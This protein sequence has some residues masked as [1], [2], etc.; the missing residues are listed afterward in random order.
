MDTT[1]SLAARY[2]ALQAKKLNIDMTR[3]KPC[4]EQLDLAADLLTC[5][6]NEDILA[7]DGSDT[8]NYGLMDG[9]P[10]AKTLFASYLD[11]ATDE[12][13]I[14][15]NSSL[16]LMYDTLLRAM[17]FGVAGSQT[18][19][20]KLPEVAF[21]CPIP[22]YD[23]HFGICETLGIKMI[24]IPMNAEGPDM[25]MVERLVAG[26]E[27]IKGMWS[28]PKYSNPS[29]L[30]YSASVVQRLAGMTT[31]AADFRIIWDNAYAVHHLSDTPDQLANLLEACK[32]AQHPDRPL[33]IGST[34][35]VSMA[36]TGVSM[37]AGSKRNIDAIKK[38]MSVQT[39]GADKVNQ[40]RHVRF[41]RDM[42]G[43]R[44]H[45]R[46][47]QAILAPKFVAVQHV[48]GAELAGTGLAE[49]SKP[50]GGYF[51]SLNTRPGKARRVIELAAAAGVK[52]T[53]AGSTS[54]YK[55]DPTDTNI[56]IAPSF[57]SVADITSA[58]EVMAVC[59]K[60]ASI[61]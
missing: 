29:G 41:F 53:P 31:K 5:V 54:P 24:P 46:K 18:P 33:I 15:G 47:H 6:S 39:I 13:I 16:S 17:L 2:A 7:A 4:S 37:I 44:G 27:H 8:R 36:G 23:R 14:G 30:T 20:S 21:L 43:V 52:L 58:M 59:I 3:G 55:K 9:I 28:V 45:M 61:E 34:A 38:Q 26:D 40:L 56:R 19:W 10:E 35:K 11:V 1:H 32:A 12:I 22:G 60:L 25:D 51:V 48:L 57:P 42:D 49:W 50:N